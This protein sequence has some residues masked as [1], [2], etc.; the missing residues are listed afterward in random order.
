MSEPAGAALPGLI[1]DRIATVL[2]EQIGQHESGHCVRVDNLR[3]A[4]AVS[5]ARTLRAGPAASQADVHVLIDRLEQAADELLIPAER[6]VELRNRKKH[7]LVLM[8]PVSTGTAASSLDN[9]FERQDA[10]DLLRV[11]SDALAENLS[12]EDGVRSAVKQV[13]GV[14]GKKRPAEAWARYVAAVSAAPSWET[15]G[16]K[17]PLVGLIPDSGGPGLA[18]RLSRNSEC[19]K[20]IS[21]PARAVS[22]VS[23]RLGKAKL[24]DGP[25][26]T[27]LLGFLSGA[28]RD[29]SNPA[30]WTADLATE[31]DLGFEHWPLAEPETVAVDQVRVEPF[32]RKNGVVVKSS[33]LKQAQAGDLPYT[34]AGEDTPG[35]VRVTWTTAPRKTEAI[36]WW[37]IEVLPP[38]D[39]RDSEEDAEPKAE[40][41]VAG[42]QRS[43]TVRLALDEADLEQGSLF[44]VRVTGLDAASQPVLLRTGDETARDESQQFTVRWEADLVTGETR[45][46][47]A[48]ALAL[49]KLDAVLGGQ[50]DL[51]EDAY[52]L[53][54]T[55]SAVSLRLGGRRTVLVGVSPLLVHLQRQLFGP[56]SSATAFTANGRMGTVLDPADLDMVEHHLPM[57]LA[58]Q[59]KE[60][61]TLLGERRPR[62]LVESLEWNDELRDKAR[63]Y[64]QAYKRALDQAATDPTYREALLAMDTLALRITIAGGQ[65]VRAV[66]V[67]PFHP[68]RLTWLA[69]YDKAVSGWA[70]ELVDSEPDKA[71]RR[72]AVDDKLIRRVTPANLP[73]AV[74]GAAAGSGAGSEAGSAIGSGTGD[75]FV[76][77]RE[78]TVGTGI[79]LAPGEREPGIAVQAVFDVLGID[80]RDVA[81]DVPPTM[82]AERI[83]A[84]RRTHSRPGA[85]RLLA[86]NPGSGELLAQALRQAVLTSRDRDSD[87]VRLDGRAEVMA[88]S[89]RLSSTDPVPALTDLQ[90]ATSG[91]RVGNTRSYLRPPLGLSVRPFERFTED[92]TPVHLSVVNDLAVVEAGHGPETAKSTTSFRNLLTPTSS[93]S[94]TTSHGRRWEIMPAVQLRE[95]R[96]GKNKDGAADAI[97]AH[98]AHQTALAAA[99]GFPAEGGIALR[100]TLGDEETK[101]LEAA[102]NRADWVLSLDRNLGLELYSPNAD[103]NRPHILDYAPDFLEGIGPRLTVTTK[104]QDEI[105]RLLSSA[106]REMSFADD[107]QSVRGA[108]RYLRMVSGRLALRLIGESDLAV[109]AVSL[110]VSLAWL[111]SRGELADTIIVPVDV[112][113]EMFGFTSDQPRLCDLIL[114][115]ANRQSIKMQCVEVKSQRQ[116]TPPEQL[117]E[118]IV[119]KIDA[120]VSML[121]NNFLRADP[122]RLDAD[123]QRARLAGILRHHANRAFA[124]GILS[125]GRLAAAERQFARI[126]DGASPEI[127]RQGYVVSLDDE[128][129]CPSQYRGTAIEVLTP[130]KILE[131]GFATAAPALPIQSP[132]LP[133]Q[134]LPAQSS[135][136]QPTMNTAEPGTPG[137]GITTPEQAVEPTPGT[138]SEPVQAAGLEQ[139]PVDDPTP[140]PPPTDEIISDADVDETESSP[141][142]ALPTEPEEP[143]SRSTDRPNE[144]RVVLG[145]DFHSAEVNWKISTS[146][147][148]HMFILGIPG[149]G[150]SVT[151]RRILSSFADQGLPA[152]V[153][154]FHGDMAANPADGATVIDAGDGL[155]FSPFELRVDMDHHKYAQAAWELAE[156]IG[157]VSGLGEI[158]R[159]VVYETLS[160]LYRRRGFGS[161]AGPIGLPNIAEFSRLLAQK[162]GSGHGRNAAARTRPLSDFGLFRED[163]G[164]GRFGELL[165]SGVVLDLHT[166]MEQVQLA[167]AAFVL[168]KVYREMFHWGKT[169]EL[170]L[171]VVLDEA[172]RLAN[173]I[174]LPKIMKEGRKYGVAVVVA[175]QG[176]DDF[177]RDVLGNA[178]TKVAFR[179]NFPQSKTVAGFL[180]GRAGQDMAQALEK[181]S[182]GQAYIST[183]DSPEARKVFM[184]K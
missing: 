60:I 132:A 100:V 97:D 150:K 119:E 49:G 74:P 159:S 139:A 73:F 75:V 121:E 125:E 77:A 120:T 87:L 179:C 162:E 32:L 18:G 117:A 99:L 83:G 92:E 58:K 37:L 126:E 146:G 4:D 115:R 130:S 31:T 123:L 105:K 55:H 9:S 56:A 26:R 64:C 180:R 175:S 160:E 176:V 19:V 95:S 76:H 124:L 163:E 40:T 78:A 61:H 157:Y 152:L 84:Y 41:T 88:Y 122:P 8:V 166:L 86:I 1:I 11:A 165:T 96:D 70:A 16:T 129:D 46:A 178:G 131:A 57:T 21:R 118:D 145:Q 153:V 51:T 138:P 6:A 174:T 90:Q 127:T 23:D 10:V 54:D 80:R 169:S 144:V 35:S 2:A 102:H 14:L 164:G 36:R 173:D 44:V 151:I 15:I 128:Y 110:A 143:G 156:V 25:V 85:I 53:D 155:D 29:L 140:D 12:D 148:P 67:L 161:V 135:P 42:S 62:D 69:E 28:R 59:R 141:G 136:L 66:V 24:Q 158:Q 181:L 147:S 43:A 142:R 50:D 45:R 170:R 20:A 108:L 112:H 72:T 3:Q 13:A 133:T 111:E 106:M 171:A 182:V 38:K 48:W 22:S 68:L 65:P 94:I 114:V 79:Y 39:M 93:H 109:E 103:V 101:V 47:S 98:R 184:N 113:Q 107:P 63:S 154:D 5:L 167:A 172:H 89:T 34:E 71:R 137:T 33:R 116:T 81:A 134:T 91:Y 168:R 17:L 82:L 7:P 149:Q 30:A 183:P 177:H 104:H 52:S 27:R